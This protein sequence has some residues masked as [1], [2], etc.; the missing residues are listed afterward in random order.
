MLA[1][2]VLGLVGTAWA[3]NRKINRENEKLAAQIDLLAST[4]AALSRSI[5]IINTEL[6]KT[7]SESEATAAQLAAEQ[8]NVS[9]FQNQIQSIG[10]TVGTLDKLSRLDP[11]LLQKYS[12]VYFLNEHYAPQHLS[13]ID[14][15]WLYHE[16]RQQQFIS[17]A[18]PELIQMLQD[19][20]STG[21]HIFVESAY[22]SF[23]D[24]ASL[25]GAYTVTYGAGTANS[26]SADQ[27]YSEHQLGTTAD[28]ITTGT[29]GSLSGFEKT[30]AYKWM[31][32]NAY[33][34]GFVLSYPPNNKYYVYE[35][36]HW[37]F[38]GKALAL[39]LRNDGKYFYD[40]DQRTI[41]QY[42]VHIFD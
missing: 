18:Y 29:G 27:G 7:Q 6:A 30:N 17:E 31:V 23:F 21:V 10:N 41:D 34:Y 36:W 9:A 39:R 42:L 3:G 24:Q 26:F 37:R 19:A 16:D 5:D 4:T 15:Q 38:V 11:E 35:P 33:K 40:L 25:K 32:D 13:M 2:L 22:R 1:A 28:F 12:K 20:S 8:S 14:P